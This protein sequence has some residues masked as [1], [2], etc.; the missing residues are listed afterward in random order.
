MTRDQLAQAG[1]EVTEEAHARL[2]RFVEALLETNRHINLTSLRVP[3]QVWAVHVCDALTLLPLIDESQARSLLDLGSGGGLPGLPIACVRP[4]LRVAL[5]DATR[6]KLSAVGG[7]CT[8][9]GLGNVEFHWGRAERLAH[10]QA[11]REEFDLVAARAVGALPLVLELASG[12]LRPHGYGLF[13]KSCQAVEGEVEAAPPAA[14]ACALVF[15]GVRTYSL[16]GE[17]GPRA[18]AVYRK[19]ARLRN[20]LPRASDQIARRAL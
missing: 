18:L 12:F 16:P 3:E 10:D 1:F 19:G 14:H 7:I 17:H 6:K 11:L 5:L 15:E 13:Y 4:E 20:S 2:A 8:G 9:L